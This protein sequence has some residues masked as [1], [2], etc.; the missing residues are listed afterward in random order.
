MD[1]IYP[2]YG[3]PGDSDT[4][5]LGER[6]RDFY[7]PED[8]VTVQN[9]D[10]KPVIYQ[11]VSPTDTETFSDY[12]GHKDTIQKKPPVR[13]TLQ[14]GETRLC[15]AHEADMIIEVLIKQ[16]TSDKVRQEIDDGTA[17]KWQSANWTN[18][19]TQKALIKEI[20]L[21]KQDVFAKY[22]K[23]QAA[24]KM[25]AIEKDLEIHAGAKK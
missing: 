2:Y 15:P 14:P 1:D 8:F 9:V 7:D 22:N 6:L 10:T 16:I 20:F 18:P 3:A 25:T 19:A 23:D 17:V 24:K 13:R 11:F 4:K 5:T 21:G 12:P